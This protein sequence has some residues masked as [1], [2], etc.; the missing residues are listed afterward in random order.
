MSVFDINYL[1]SRK[2]LPVV[3]IDEFV[4]AKGIYDEGM[5]TYQ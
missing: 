3:Y 1:Q 2:E 5:E 4:L